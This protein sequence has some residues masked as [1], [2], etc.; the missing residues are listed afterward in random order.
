M[1]YY[2]IFAILAIQAFINDIAGIKLKKSED[3]I[4]FF[5]DSVVLFF[6]A[7]FRSNVGSDWDIYE[8]IF[9]STGRL[10]FLDIFVRNLQSFYGGQYEVGYLSLNWIL[11]NSSFQFLIFVCSFL[12]IIPKLIYFY[13]YSHKKYVML[14]MYFTT[15]FIYYDIIL[16]RQ[17][18]ALSFALWAYKNFIGGKKKTFFFNVLLGSCFHITCISMFLLPVIKK[19]KKQSL[20]KYIFFVIVAYVIYSLHPMMFLSSIIGQFGGSGLLSFKIGYYAAMSS[21]SNSNLL[22]IVKRLSVFIIMLIYFLSSSRKE[23]QEISMKNAVFY[24]NSY[25]ISILIM[26]LS[27][28]IVMIGSRGTIFLYLAHFF[29]IDEIMDKERNAKVKLL[30]FLIIAVLLINTLLSTISQ[31]QLIPYNNILL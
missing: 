6:M 17:G 21:M 16:I 11:R 15:I 14:F 10:D 23:E 29:V 30:L 19:T 25:Y 20:V 3:A 22:N 8:R 2:A 9:N 24:L 26:I 5:A 31:T 4:I 7:A 27:Q 1:V 12:C 13:K 28:D 18:I